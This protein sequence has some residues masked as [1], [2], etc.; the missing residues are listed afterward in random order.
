MKSK[1]WV[2]GITA[3]G[4]SVSCGGKNLSTVESKTAKTSLEMKTQVSS[5]TPV[6][7]KTTPTPSKATA[8]VAAKTKNLDPNSPLRV[9]KDYTEELRAIAGLEKRKIKAALDRDQE[10]E[11][12]EKVR[13]FFDFP[14]LAQMSLGHHWK[15]TSSSRRQEFSKL[16]I[17]LVED[18]YLRRSRDL[19]GNYDLSF[20]TQRIQGNKAKVICSVAHKDANIDIVYELHQKTGG[21]MIYNIVLDDVDLIRNYQSQFNRII[22]RDGFSQLLKLMRKKLN[23]NGHPVDDVPL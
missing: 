14:S 4:L 22:Q 21:W 6:L 13:Q 23:N 11:I 18:S 9:I 3:L 16:F 1:L 5:S 10:Q 20:N 8:E 7:G 12:A 19:V 2:L 17:N 15:T